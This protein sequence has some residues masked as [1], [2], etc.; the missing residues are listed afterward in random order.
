MK[1]TVPIKKNYEFMRVYK[2][3]IFYVGRNIVLYVLNNNTD[4]NR[5]GI[6]VSKKFGKSVKRNRIKRLIRENYRYYE[7]YVKNSCDMV[8]VARSSEVMPCSV[9]IRKEMKFLLKKLGIFDQEK[10]DC[11]KG[12]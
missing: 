1:R 12:Y 9:E 4:V 5:L 8:I 3:G 10:W 7:E 2:K 6:T 11:L